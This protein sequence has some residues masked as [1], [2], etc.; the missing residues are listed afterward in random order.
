MT[1]KSISLLPSEYRKMKKTIRRRE[2][3]VAVLGILA[4][5]IVFACVIVKMFAAI[6]GEK[7]KML[8]AENESLLQSIRALEYLNELEENIRNEA[9]LA[10]K[11]VGNQPDWL[12]LYTS[13]SAS[14]PDG[15]QLSSITAEPEETKLTFIIQGN[16]RSNATLSDW[17][18]RLKETDIFTGTELKYA[19][20]A[21]ESGNTIAFEIKAEARNDQPF[22]LFGE[23]MK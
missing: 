5:A 12:T 6:P 20:V 14:I 16:A 2:I 15:L 22:Q 7:L 9:D 17:M 3:L 19:R 11:A 23:A 4:L 21:D 18:D 10:Q 8:K 13:I 1:M